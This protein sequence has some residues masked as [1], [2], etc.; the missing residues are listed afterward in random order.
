MQ[1]Y[2]LD[3][4]SIALTMAPTHWGGRLDYDGTLPSLVTMGTC[5]FSPDYSDLAGFFVALC[6]GLLFCSVYKSI[7]LAK[8]GIWVEGRGVM[9][10]EG[11]GEER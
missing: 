10:G 11:R 9:G 4:Y 2:T 7:P 1:H 6:D 8:L 5:H 3:G